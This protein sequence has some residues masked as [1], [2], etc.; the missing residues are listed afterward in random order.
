MKGYRVPFIL[1]S[2]QIKVAL[3]LV[4]SKEGEEPMA[5]E[6]WEMGQKKNTIMECL[7]PTEWVGFVL[8]VLLVA[9]KYIALVIHVSLTMRCK[10]TPEV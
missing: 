2:C 10:T 3:Q 8:N 9:K 7:I 5:V 4:L 1:E 6:I